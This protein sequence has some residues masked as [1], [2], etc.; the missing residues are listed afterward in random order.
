MCFK[1]SSAERGRRRCTASAIL[2]IPGDLRNGSKFLSSDGPPAVLRLAGDLLDGAE[3]LVAAGF[4]D[5]PATTV[6]E[7]TIGLLC[8]WRKV[9][10][11]LLDGAEVPVAAGFDDMLATTEEEFTIGLLCDRRKV[12]GKTAPLLAEYCNVTSPIST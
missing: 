2:I 6:E 3:V 9:A 5:M 11:D 8:D 7:F 12:A 1:P 10:V 4:D